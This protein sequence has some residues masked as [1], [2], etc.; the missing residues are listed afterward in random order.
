MITTPAGL[1]ARLRGYA[2]GIPA[3]TRV[4]QA[5]ALRRY[6]AA[7]GADASSRIADALEVL[8]S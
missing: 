6:V 3:V 4:R 1:E 7:S 5:A 2:T 8:A